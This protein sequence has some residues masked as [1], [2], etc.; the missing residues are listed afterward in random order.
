MIIDD[1]DALSVEQILWLLHPP[2]E[3]IL[4]VK[5]WDPEST[6][7]TTTL[8]SRVE[9]TACTDSPATGLGRA[10]PDRME[11]GRR[12]KEV[13]GVKNPRELVNEC[14]LNGGIAVTERGD[15]DTREKIEIATTLII[16]QP[17]TLPSDYIC[18]RRPIEL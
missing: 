2:G 13:R 11:S 8:G 6:N 7:P 17:G 14:L 1:I 9:P 3:G 5:S 18:H 15:R 10:H 12:G 16:K 4:P